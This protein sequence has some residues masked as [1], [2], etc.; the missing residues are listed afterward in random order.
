MKELEDTA[1][2]ADVRKI[3]YDGPKAVRYEYTAIIHTPDVDIESIK[4][5]SIDIVRDYVNSVG[6]LIFI[7]IMIPMG[8]Y[9]KNLYPKKEHLEVT[10]IRDRLAEAGE[11]YSLDYGTEEERFKGVFLMN[12]NPAVNAT[13]YQQ[14]DKFSLDLMDIP[15]VKLQLLNRAL[16]PIRIKTMGGIFKGIAVGDLIKSVLSTESNRITVDGSGSISGIDIV[17]PDN[18]EIR[19]H[20]VIPDSTL[21][22]TLPSILQENIGGVYNSGLGNYLQTYKGRLTWFVYPLF[23]TTRFKKNVPKAVFFSVPARRL[24]GIERTFRKES[25]IV[26]IIATSSKAYRSNGETAMMDQGS[27]Y[28]LTDSRPMMHKPVEM[29]PEG[30]VGT[31]AQINHEVTTMERTDGLN[32]APVGNQAMS[33]NPFAEASRVLQRRGG[34]VDFEWYHAA[35]EELY[36]GMPCQFVFLNDKDVIEKLNGIVLFVHTYIQLNGKG[37]MAMAHTTQSAV[38][39]FIEPVA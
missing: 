24:A 17:P 8:D 29:T 30:P 22:T 18:Q 32:Y 37:I 33:C 20:I 36:P 2:W 34:R 26:N 16:E 11:Y 13:E 28:R 7:Q 5:V 19:D 1:L 14:F 12:E 9:I 23:N 21:I 15:T 27:G 35:P 39:I 38:T 10:V 25:N 3:I 4:V 31:R 6:D